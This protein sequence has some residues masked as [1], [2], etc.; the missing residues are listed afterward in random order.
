MNSPFFQDIEASMDNYCQLPS[1]VVHIPPLPK[2]YSTQLHHCG[3]LK[4]CITNLIFDAL[5][6]NNLIFNLQ[7]N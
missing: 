7:I 4:T 3:S 6:V 2:K 1:D 5:N